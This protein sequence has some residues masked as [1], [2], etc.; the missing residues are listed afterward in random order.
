[1]TMLS[2]D[3]EGYKLLKWFGSPTNLSIKSIEQG[4]SKTIE[5]FKDRIGHLPVA[6]VFSEKDWIKL[7]KPDK[8]GELLVKTKSKGIPNG[9]YEVV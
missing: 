5:F 9:I 4:L 8:I 7:G 1:M 6:I 2:V 3:T